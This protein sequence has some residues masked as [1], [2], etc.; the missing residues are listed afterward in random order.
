MQS[1]YEIGIIFDEFL[2]G[3]RKIYLRHST[4]PDDHQNILFRAGICMLSYD[5]MHNFTGH[6]SQLFDALLDQAVAENAG[7]EDIIEERLK[8][9]TGINITK[10]KKAKKNRIPNKYKFFSCCTWRV[11]S[12][13]LGY[14]FDGLWRTD[15]IRRDME[16]CSQL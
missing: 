1:E 2:R 3:N 4:D 10:S 11:V 15:A 5:N 8:E 16:T 13:N 12:L 7:N 14:I 9:I 6:V